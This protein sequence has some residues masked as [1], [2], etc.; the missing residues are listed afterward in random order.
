MTYEMTLREREIFGRTKK[1]EE[2]ALRMLEEGTS[3]DFIHRMTELSIE[4]IKK[5]AEQIKS[6]VNRKEID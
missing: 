4:R 3:L 6:G 5:L 1:A 2:I